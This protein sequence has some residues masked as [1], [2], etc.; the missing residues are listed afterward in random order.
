ML[1]IFKIINE[2]KYPFLF[3]DRITF[4]FILF[5]NK[6][7]KKKYLGINQA[8]ILQTDLFIDI[9]LNKYQGNKTKF[10]KEKCEAEFSLL[11]K[12]LQVRK[13]KLLNKIPQIFNA[14][15]SV[16]KLCYFLVR[17]KKPEIIVETGLANGAS[18]FIILNAIKEN[19][20]GIL[21][22]VDL[23]PL[24]SEHEIG[25]LVNERL[26]SNWHIYKGSSLRILS[27]INKKVKKID[28]F[29]HDSANIYTIQKF[30]VKKIYGTLSPNGIII[31]NNIGTSSAFNELVKELKPSAS[32]IVEQIEKKSDLTG[33]LIK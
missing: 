29:L 27:K 33:I 31:M 9:F 10:V 5:Y 23:P 17:Y 2:I 11:S 22:S 18:S 7:F 25:L 24:S 14:D 1:N 6:K 8:K 3:L 26:K 21:H 4:Y 32:Y 19:N 20:Q 28:L 16:A 13:K 30:E 12:E 15:V